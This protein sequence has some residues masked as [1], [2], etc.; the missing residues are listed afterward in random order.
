M[1]GGGSA[2]L[3]GGRSRLRL[4]R[5][6][7]CLKE[8]TI[9]NELLT[10]LWGITCVWEY[11]GGRKCVG[12]WKLHEFGM[13]RVRPWGTPRATSLFVWLWPRGLSPW[14]QTWYRMLVFGPCIGDRCLVISAPF[15]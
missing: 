11:G 9:K 15:Q 5:L 12:G 7:A 4:K 1:E 8:T 13:K 2:D 10:M 6:A 14:L 3:V